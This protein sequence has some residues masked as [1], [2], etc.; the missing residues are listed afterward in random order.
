MREP[1][2]DTSSP[3]P[4]PKAVVGRLSLYL[5]QLESFGRQGRETVSSSQLGQAL[6]LNDAQV[7]KDL[8]YFGQ[9]GQP[10]LG[11]RID[12]LVV[13]IR[14]ILGVDRDWP[15]ALIGLGNLGRAL[16]GYKGFRLRR[17][18]VVSLFDNDPRKQGHAF[19]GLPVRHTDELPAAVADEGLRLA[20]I[21][22]PADAAQRVAD[23]VV[24]AGIRGILNF[25]PTS[26]FVPP[27]VSVVAVDLSVQLEHLAYS[28][29]NL[30]GSGA[31]DDV[32]A[33]G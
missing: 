24:S 14:G 5:R 29:H 16:L 23:Q 7:R 20:M 4:A 9:F 2:H 15:T 26:L 21:C 27:E 19:D 33:A 25:A 3:K 30:H 32:S 17:F 22:V 1:H 13:E 12:D 10:G 6:G 11:Y 18:R 31:T 28:V 8:A